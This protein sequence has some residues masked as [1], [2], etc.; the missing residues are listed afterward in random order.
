MSTTPEAE[1]FFRSRLDQRIDLRRPL[2]QLTLRM[3]WQALEASIAHLFARK[4]RAGQRIDDMDL[5]GGS[6]G[7]V[8]GGISN[9]GRPRV[10]LRMMISLLYLKHAYNESDEGVVERWSQ[11]PAWQYF[12]GLEYFEDRL[13][14]DPTVL[15]RFR[16]ALPPRQTSCRPLRSR[17]MGAQQRCSDGAVW[18]SI[19]EASGSETAATERDFG[20][21]VI[22]GVRDF[23]RYAGALAV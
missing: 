8:G 6:S 22:A 9:A 20:G 4:A 7:V 19:Q 13:P 23:C 21:G 17:R 15:V 2:P 5:F 14:C 10:P 11:T 16:R 12:S 1:D 3:P 18:S